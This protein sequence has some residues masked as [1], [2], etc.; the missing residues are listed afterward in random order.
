MQHRVLEYYQDGSN[1]E[2]RLTLTYFISRSNVVP[3]FLWEE[4]NPMDFSETIGVCDIK[5]GRNSQ[6]NEYM[7]LMSFN[8]QGYSLALVQISQIQYF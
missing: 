5:V 8:G 1:D 6:L 3:A 2:S 4:D 7:K